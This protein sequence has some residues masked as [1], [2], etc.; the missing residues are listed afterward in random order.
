ME[1]ARQSFGLD[2]EIGYVGITPDEWV[3]RFDVADGRSVFF[4]PIDLHRPGFA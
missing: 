1:I 3:K 2:I 4:A